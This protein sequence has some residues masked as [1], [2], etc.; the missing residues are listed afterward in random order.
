MLKAALL[1][2]N[3]AF[4]LVLLSGFEAGLA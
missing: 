3:L 1:Y 4:G 2:V